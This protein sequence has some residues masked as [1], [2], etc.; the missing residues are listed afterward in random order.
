MNEIVQAHQMQLTGI[1]ENLFTRFIAYIDAKPKTIETYT[2]ALRQ[3]IRYL[4]TR[5]IAQPTRGDILAYRDELKRNVKPSTVQMYVIAVRQFFKWM[6]QEGLYPN[7]ADNVK[8]ARIEKAHKKDALTSRAIKEVLS[9]ID[10]STLTGKRDYAIFALMVTGGLR[11]IEVARAN[12]EDIR[13]VADTTVLYIQGKGKDEKADYVKLPAPVDKAIR[14]YLQAKGKADPGEP[15]FTSTSNNNQGER[16]TTR[17]ISGIVK[18]RLTAA[19]YD[20][21]RLTAHSL[22]HTAGTLNLVNGGSLEET[23]QLLRHSNINTTMIYL[24][25]IERAKNQSEQRIAGAIF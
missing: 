18:A 13:T 23:Q 2:R 20:S 10:R 8:G 25:H 14:D 16:I 1:N 9:T 4:H 19:G 24:H 7:I 21:D 15:L 3:F 17:S 5:S 6:H 22:R 12:I 11:T